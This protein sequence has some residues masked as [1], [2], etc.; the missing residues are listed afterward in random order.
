MFKKMGEKSLEV[1]ILETTGIK[2]R[3]MNF[4]RIF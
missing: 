3:Y 1:N 2:A 4:A